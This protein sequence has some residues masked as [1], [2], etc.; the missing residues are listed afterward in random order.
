MNFCVLVI[1]FDGTVG[2]TH[3]LTVN[4]SGTTKFGNTVST[5]SLTTDAAGT[6]QLFNN[7]TTSGDQTFG[8][9]P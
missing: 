6:T 9:P 1:D 8:N 4:S 3:N 7:V 2:G 5:N